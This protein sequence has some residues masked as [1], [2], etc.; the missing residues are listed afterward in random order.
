MIRTAPLLAALCLSGCAAL[1]GTNEFR[2]RP[3]L[4]DGDDGIPDKEYEPECLVYVVDEVPKRGKRVGTIDVPLAD[5]EAGRVDESSRSY[6]CNLKA[7]HAVKEEEFTDRR[8]HRYWKMGV[9]RVSRS[10]F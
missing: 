1:A 3:A 6:A 5:A 4:F 7:T 10:F 8:G 9:Y 2:H